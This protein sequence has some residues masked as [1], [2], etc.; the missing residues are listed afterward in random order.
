MIGFLDTRLDTAQVAKRFHD[1]SVWATLGT[2]FAN[3]E[4]IYPTD[5]PQSNFETSARLNTAPYQGV[6][7]RF[8][9]SLGR[10]DN[11]EKNDSFNAGYKSYL[12][13]VNGVNNKPVLGDY[14]YIEG[15]GTE[16]NYY[17]RY[18]PSENI[19]LPDQL[20]MRGVIKYAVIGCASLAPGTKITDTNGN[21]YLSCG[22]FGWQ[23]FRIA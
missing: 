22:T 1:N 6:W 5:P 4:F 11:H 21:T 17:R 8:T 23:G 9:V 18:N 7:D 19:Y 13:Q 12:G 14:Y 20:Y 3:H 15:R 10:Y 2:D 16:N